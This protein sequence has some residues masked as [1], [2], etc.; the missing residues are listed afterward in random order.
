MYGFWYARMAYQNGIDVDLAAIRVCGEK[1][2]PN[3]L[4]SRSAYFTI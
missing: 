4:L 3:K 1:V 2:V